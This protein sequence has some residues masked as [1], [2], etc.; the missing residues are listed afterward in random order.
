M[1]TLHTVIQGECLSS[2]AKRYGFSHWRTIYDHP[3]NAGFKRKRP[4]PN[5]IYP[6]D[7]IFIPDRELKQKTGGTEK[8]H[9]LKLKAPRT[10]LRIV[11]QDHEGKTLSGKKYKLKLEDREYQGATAPDGLIE[12][13]IAADAEKGELLVWMEGDGSGECCTLPLKVGHLDPVEEITGVQAR[14]NNLGFYC[15]KIDG[16]LGPKTTGALKAFQTKY[17]SKPGAKP[18][19]RLDDAT[20]NKLREIHDGA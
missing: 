12:Q 2:I 14:L 7:E 5:V 4:N 1:A 17:L 20:R 8:R 10:F 3:Q 15:G 9:K 16:I 19:G 11:L 18:S 6:G 13:E